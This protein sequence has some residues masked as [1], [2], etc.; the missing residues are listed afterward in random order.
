MSRSRFGR[1][2]GAMVKAREH[3]Q[4]DGTNLTGAR[5]NADVV[6]C[7]LSALFIVGVLVQVF[8]AGVGVFGMNALKVQ[9]ASSFDLHRN[10]GEVLGLL[11]VVMLILALVARFSRR[12]IF[13]TLTL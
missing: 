13:E 2:R 1:S 11:S 7:Y 10:F 12:T 8:L 9:N 3:E 4:N 5:R 6:Y